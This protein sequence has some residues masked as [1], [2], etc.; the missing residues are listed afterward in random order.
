MET[1]DTLAVAE[2]VYR[3]AT[4]VD[5]RDWALYRSL[6]ADTVAVDFSSFAP[7]LRP[8]VMSGDDWVA[9]VVPLFT[10]LAATQHSMTNPLATVEGDAATITMYVRAHH[11]YD[12]DDPTSWYT[13]GGYYDDTL[14]RVDDRWLLTGVRLTVTWRA[15]DPGVM[16]L[17]RSAGNRLLGR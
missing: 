11:V 9:G 10:G 8:A 7:D 15:G 2:T 3:Y 5:R 17:A 4:G 1:T 12:P 6:F 14:A 13:V 16:E